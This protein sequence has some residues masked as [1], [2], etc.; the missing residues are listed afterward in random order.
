[1]KLFQLDME[2]DWRAEIFLQTFVCLFRPRKK[3]FNFF[4][5]LLLM[6]KNSEF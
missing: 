5:V 2:E 1:M 4:L 3:K 6:N